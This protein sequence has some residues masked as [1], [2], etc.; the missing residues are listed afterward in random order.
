MFGWAQRDS[1][2]GTGPKVALARIAELA[3]QAGVEQAGKPIVSGGRASQRAC[4]PLIGQL[5]RSW[6]WFGDYFFWLGYRGANCTWG[7]PFNGRLSL[8]R[9]SQLVGRRW[10]LGRTGLEI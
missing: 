1:P 5:P 3:C 10:T 7:K 9:L 6:R 4:Q 2:A 8:R